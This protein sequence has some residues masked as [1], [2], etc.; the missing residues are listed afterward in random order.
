[1]CYAT[2][3]TLRFPYVNQLTLFPVQLRMRASMV[4]VLRK[5]V[6]NTW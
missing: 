3:F 1:M 6:N 5:M 4:D 2:L